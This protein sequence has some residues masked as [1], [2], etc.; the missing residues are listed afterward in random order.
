MIKTDWLGVRFLSQ[1]SVVW[2]AAAA[3]ADDGDD[4]DDDKSRFLCKQKRKMLFFN[5]FMNHSS[6]YSSDL[7]FLQLSQRESAALSLTS[8][9]SALD[10]LITNHSHRGWWDTPPPC[11]YNSSCLHWT[12][13]VPSPDERRADRPITAIM[14]RSCHSAFFTCQQCQHPGQDSYWRHWNKSEESENLLF[15]VIKVLVQ[16]LNPHEAQTWESFTS[17][18]AAAAAASS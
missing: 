14:L 12:P 17:P 3:A 7:L 5:H 6:F 16:C 9:W 15:R 1:V 4:D 11:H 10:N 18:D 13:A 8:R 2:S